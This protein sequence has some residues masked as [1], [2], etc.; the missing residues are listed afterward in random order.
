MHSTE[1]EPSTGHYLRSSSLQ[2]TNHDRMF[3]RQNQTVPSCCYP[4]RLEGCQLPPSAVA[5]MGESRFLF[6][7][8]KASIPNARASISQVQ[9]AWR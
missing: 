7:M 8:M 5:R 6:Q 2:E 9:L 4:L 1:E 3:L